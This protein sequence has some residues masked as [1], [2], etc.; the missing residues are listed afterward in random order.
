MPDEW[1]LLWLSRVIPTVVV[2][3]VLCVHSVFIVSSGSSF[4]DSVCFYQ[5]PVNSALTK[6]EESG[7]VNRGFIQTTCF[8]ARFFAQGQFMSGLIWVD[9][10]WKPAV[11]QMTGSSK[12]QDS[13]LS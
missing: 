2:T 11:L 5:G 13:P 6:T 1:H 3:A 10:L 12:H 9:N 8:C 4:E 7:A